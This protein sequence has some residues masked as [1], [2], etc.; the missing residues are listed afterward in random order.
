MSYH[1]VQLPINKM[2]PRKIVKQTNKRRNTDTQELE[3]LPTN[4]LKPRNKAGKLGV[5]S[6]AKFDY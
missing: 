5:G 4:P 1:P 2:P 3:T 6:M